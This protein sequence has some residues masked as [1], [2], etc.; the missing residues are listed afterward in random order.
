MGSQFKPQKLSLL[1]EMA[2]NL[3]NGAV[4]TKKQTGN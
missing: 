2:E 3:T 1:A 4:S